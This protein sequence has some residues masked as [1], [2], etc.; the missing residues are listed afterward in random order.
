MMRSPR[1]LC[2]RITALIMMECLSEYPTRG[3]SRRAAVGNIIEEAA[4]RTMKMSMIKLKIMI[5][6]LIK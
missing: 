1:S 6:L 2:A 3:M 5:K 4:T